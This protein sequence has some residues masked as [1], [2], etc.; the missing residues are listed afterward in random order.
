MR[1][2]YKLGTLVQFASSGTQG[3]GHGMVTAVIT[4]TTG[5]QYEVDEIKEQFLE[6]S[7]ITAAFR[8]VTQRKT[9]TKQ[10]TKTAKK[11]KTNENSALAS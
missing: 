6:E 3:N 4:R 10:P 11:Q 5:F 7:E 1:A 8:P 2:K 9:K